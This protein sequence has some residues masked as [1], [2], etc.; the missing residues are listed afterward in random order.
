MQFMNVALAG[1]DPGEFQPTPAS[2][3]SPFARKVDTPDVA[4]GDGELH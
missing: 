4:P 3:N 1:K 2:E